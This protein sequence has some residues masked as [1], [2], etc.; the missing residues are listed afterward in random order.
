MADIFE[1]FK[2][3][4][5]KTPSPSTPPTHII[6]GLGN[7]GKEYERTRH[8]AGFMALD[9]LAG[10]LHADVSRSKFNALCGDAMLGERRV[11]LMKPLTFMNSSGESIRDAADFYK[12]PPENILVLVDDIYQD[13]GRMRVRKN[14]SD[15][16]QRG[17]KSIIYQLSSDQFPRIR[18]GVGQ[19]PN[20]AYEL[21]DWVL[22]VFPQA[23]LAA[24]Q[25][26]FP[27]LEEA[28]K[29]IFDGKFENAMG[30]CNGHR[31]DNGVS[32]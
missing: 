26:C 1:L 25:S 7:P 23:D 32:K 5:K 24:L 30:L 10:R 22:G 9:Y 17:L 3:I 15:G 16:G 12:I 28:A 2:L 18:F 21:K 4:E 19:K 29:L 14:G 8:N 27:L 13:A 6:A 31:P 11:L 20:P